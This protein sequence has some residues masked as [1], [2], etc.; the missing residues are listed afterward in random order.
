MSRSRAPR[1]EVLLSDVPTLLSVAREAA[2][3]FRRPWEALGNPLPTNRSGR[4]GGDALLLRDL[5]CAVRV[6]LHEDA[7]PGRGPRPL[8]DRRPLP[9]LALSWP[10]SLTWNSPRI[11]HPV[12]KSPLIW[13][14]GTNRSK[15]RGLK[16]TSKPTR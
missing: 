12:P 10:R 4:G 9:T 11:P 7:H 14:D 3:E 5:D 8:G 16:V 1:V 2:A 6:H 15:S 13:M